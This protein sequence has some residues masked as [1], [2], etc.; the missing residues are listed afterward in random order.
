VRVLGE[1]KFRREVLLLCRSKAEMNYCELKAQM[2][3]DVLLWPERFYNSFV[4]TRIHRDH[5]LKF[6]KFLDER[7]K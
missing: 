6:R 7:S 2:D 4:G 3:R 5:L 1:R